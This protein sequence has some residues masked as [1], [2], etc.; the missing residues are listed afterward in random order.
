M[1]IVSLDSKTEAMRTNAPRQPTVP[2]CPAAKPATLQAAAR[3]RGSAKVGWLPLTV[4]EPDSSGHATR[5]RGFFRQYRIDVGHH[6][7]LS[8]R[9]LAA[10]R[11]GA[12]RG[13]RR[14]LLPFRKQTGGQ[15]VV[16]RVQAALL[17]FVVDLDPGEI[18]ALRVTKQ[19]LQLRPLEAGCFTWG[20]HLFHRVLFFSPQGVENKAKFQPSP[21]GACSSAVRAGDS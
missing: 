16:G 11:Q 7:H 21:T 12:G 14:R 19:V 6:S 1:G 9:D 8:H 10:Q 18:Y 5:H 3:L 2:R 17:G 4:L 20:C 13:R 15:V